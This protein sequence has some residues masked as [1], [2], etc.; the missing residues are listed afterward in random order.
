MKQ[1][2]FKHQFNRHLIA[3]AA[4]LFFTLSGNLNA[5]AQT[6]W[7]VEAG[8][9]ASTL[10]DI[11][12]ICDN[13][14]IKA[15]VNAGIFALH[16]LNDWVTIKTG[17]SYQG[18]G[19]KTELSELN[20]GLTGN[21]ETEVTGTLHYAVLP[22]QAEFSSAKRDT[23]HLFFSTGPYLGFLIESDYELNDE[24]I[25]IENYTDDLDFGWSFE[26]GAEFPFLK[27][28]AIRT[29]LSYEMGLK[30]VVQDDNCDWRNKTASFKLGLLF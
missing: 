30:K 11:G 3:L 14:D 18:K 19:K 20:L 24:K 27:K 28:N 25:E 29:S 17:V 10:S 8:I 12:N 22:L 21:D 1:N 16:N 5:N 23:K 9:N 15:G 4:M 13:N 7:V 6:D 2:T 26:L